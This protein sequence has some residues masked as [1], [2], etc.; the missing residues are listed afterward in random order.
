MRTAYKKKCNANATQVNIY[1]Q[2]GQHDS[3]PQRYLE[4]VREKAKEHIA[5]FPTMESHYCRENSTRKYLEE[6]LTISLMYRLYVAKMVSEKTEYVSRQIYE[7]I[8][9]SFNYGFFKPKKTGM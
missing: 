5:S 3:R 4:S 7:S 9:N 8:L 2:R 6:G 1:D